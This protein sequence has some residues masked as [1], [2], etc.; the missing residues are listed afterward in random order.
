M[1]KAAIERRKLRRERVRLYSEGWFQ[2]ESL[3]L[4]AP[5]QYPNR[6]NPSSFHG[7]GGEERD[8]HFCV[9]QRLL[10]GMAFVQGSYGLH[11][12]GGCLF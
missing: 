9:N 1:H 10:V 4:M 5:T 3:P 6:D 7:D 8:A 11:A 2:R 12:A